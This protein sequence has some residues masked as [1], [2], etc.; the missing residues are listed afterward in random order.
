MAEDGEVYSLMNF[1]GTASWMSICAMAASVTVCEGLTVLTIAALA[2]LAT[3]QTREI[4][5]DH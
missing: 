4:T 2:S 1:A 3:R 5:V